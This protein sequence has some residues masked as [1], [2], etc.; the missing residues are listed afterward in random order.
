MCNN[1]MCVRMPMFIH[2]KSCPSV[3]LAGI[4]PHIYATLLQ[5]IKQI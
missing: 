5:K 2:Y 1:M 4:F 3:L